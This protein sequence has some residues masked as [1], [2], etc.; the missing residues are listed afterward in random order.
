MYP[1]LY[2]RFNLWIVSSDVGETSHHSHEWGRCMLF[3]P[4]LGRW[5]FHP[6]RILS[7][8]LVGFYNSLP[9]AIYPPIGIGFR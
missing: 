3:N 6:H 1:R 8:Q 2:S 5:D 7:Y 9:T 4:A